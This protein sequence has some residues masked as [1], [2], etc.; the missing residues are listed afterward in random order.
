MANMFTPPKKMGPGSN[1]KTGPGKDKKNETPPE[2]GQKP[3][4]EASEET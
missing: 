2:N 4:Q 1:K 3:G